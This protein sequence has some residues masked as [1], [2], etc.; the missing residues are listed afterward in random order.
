MRLE[1]DLG[2]LESCDAQGTKSS[3][4]GKR[5]D[6]KEMNPKTIFPSTCPS[7]A[8]ISHRISFNFLLLRTCSRQVTFISLSALQPIPLRNRR[9][10]H[11]HSCRSS[12]RREQVLFVL[13][14]WFQVVS[15]IQFF[16]PSQLFPIPFI[17]FRRSTQTRPTSKRDT[18]FPRTPNIRITK[19]EK[20]KQSKFAHC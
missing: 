6:K 8:F 9:N 16:F 18:Y 19:F 20:E 3:L 11:S 7:S 17:L 14:S 2:I 1:S 15:L 5:R 13:S 12:L 10:S 4:E